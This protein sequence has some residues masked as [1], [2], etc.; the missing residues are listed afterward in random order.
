MSK[1]LPHFIEVAVAIID[2]IKNISY[3]NIA[4]TKSSQFNLNLIPNSSQKFILNY[5]PGL[6]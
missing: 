5:L 4:Y 1:A 3:H 2:N 6:M